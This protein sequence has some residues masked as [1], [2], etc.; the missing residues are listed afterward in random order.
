MQSTFCSHVEAIAMNSQSSPAV[1][2]AFEPPV[3]LPEAD[4]FRA[5]R[6]WLYILSALIVI[7]VLVGGAT[8]LTDSGLSITKWNLL[9]GFIPP[10]NAAHWQAEFLLYQTTDEFKIQNSS[11][12]M[13]QFKV[14]YWWEWAHR[15][16]GRLIGLTVLVPMIVFWKMGRLTPWLKKAALGLFVLV[17]LQGFIGWWMVKSGLVDRVDVSQIRLAIHLT[18]ACI[19]LAAT[20]WVARS[21]AP[22]TV[23]GDNAGFAQTGWLLLLI[24]LQIFIGGLVAGLDAGM[25]YNTWPDMNG[26]IIPQSLWAATPF[27]VNLTDNALTVQFFHRCIAYL[28]W[29]AVLAHAVVMLC[30]NPSSPHAR[31]ALL[32]FVLVT[33]QALIGITTLLLQVPFSWA[34]LHQLGAVV[35]LAFATA[36]WRALSPPQIEVRRQQVRNSGPAYGA[37]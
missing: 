21:V 10:L 8:R 4:Q 22:H 31:R 11:M 35:V 30:D 14:I 2:V 36:H 27:W 17:C 7:M 29:F 32:L 24:L 16:L 9:I 18:T 20:I 28:L 34:L 1:A 3:K 12:T 25:A 23:A 33:V 6:I 19:F 15:F 13:D 37:I 26:E 5:I